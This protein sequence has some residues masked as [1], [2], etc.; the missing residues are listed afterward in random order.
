MTPK[1]TLQAL[2]KAGKPIAR[3]H[4]YRLLTVLDIKP[5]GRSRPAIYP[6]DTVERI[7]SHLGISS[8]GV[9]QKRQNA[10]SAL[11][12]ARSAGCEVPAPSAGKL[13]SVRALRAAKPQ[14]KTKVKI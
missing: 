14:H 8:G 9:V 13:I 6:A 11:K 12:V 10:G 7:K 5:L 3:S 4:L 2:R 1:Q